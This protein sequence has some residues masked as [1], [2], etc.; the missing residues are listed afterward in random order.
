MVWCTGPRSRRLC[1]K[2]WDG[3][4]WYRYRNCCRLEKLGGETLMVNMR[5]S[6]ILKSVQLVLA[7][8]MKHQQWGIKGNKN[9]HCYLWLAC[10]TKGILRASF[11]QSSET[12]KFTP[13]ELNGRISRWNHAISPQVFA[14]CA[15]PFN[16]LVQSSWEGCTRCQVQTTMQNHD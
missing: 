15:Y 12:A 2:V 16:T 10:F 14:A 8:F 11:F 3:F 13:N 5:Y 4:W 6:Q 9:I 1:C 7:R